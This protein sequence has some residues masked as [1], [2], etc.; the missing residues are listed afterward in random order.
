MHFIDVDVEEIIF[1][2]KQRIA[3]IPENKL[4]Q[5]AINSITMQVTNLELAY[6]GGIKFG[7]LFPHC[8]SPLFIIKGIIYFLS[9]GYVKW[10]YDGIND[11]KNSSVMFDY[12][13]EDDPN[14][15]LCF[16]S[17]LQSL[18]DFIPEKVQGLLSQQELAKLSYSKLVK[19]VYLSDVEIAYS[20]KLG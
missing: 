10:I 6:Q 12:W 5:N 14:M 15:S 1:L 2:R 19:D 3:M 4:A 9:K 20:S 16:R 8:E 17:V 11:Y 7:N 18:K 13:P